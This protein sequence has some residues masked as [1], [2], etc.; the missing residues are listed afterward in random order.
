MS[1]PQKGGLGSGDGDTDAGV[2]VLIFSAPGS[3]LPVLLGYLE[4]PV[5]LI[6]LSGFFFPQAQKEERSSG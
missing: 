2:L 1:V 4:L 6:N 5:L 3:L